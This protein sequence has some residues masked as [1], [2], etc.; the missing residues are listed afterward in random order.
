VRL[1]KNPEGPNLTPPESGFELYRHGNAGGMKTRNWH[2][3]YWARRTANGDYEIRS[4]PQSLGEPSAPGG[5]FPERGFE[6][7]YDKLEP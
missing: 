7:Y 3:L 6:R 2:G 4:V 5:T 1:P